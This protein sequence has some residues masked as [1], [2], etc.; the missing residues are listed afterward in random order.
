[1]FSVECMKRQNPI[2][3]RYKARAPRI[4]DFTCPEIDAI[5]Q[6]L[7][8]L[9]ITQK[10]QRWLTRHLESLRQKNDQLR[11][12]SQYWYDIVKSWLQD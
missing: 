5:I 2:L 1:M 12:S 6:R 4:P 10:D 8:G 3:K 7:Q 11:E 9:E